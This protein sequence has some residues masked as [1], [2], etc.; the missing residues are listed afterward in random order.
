MSIT[1]TSIK[2]LTKYRD[3]L[4]KIKIW[5]CNTACG[6]SYLAKVDKR[7]YDLD[8]YRSKMMQQGL[9][10]FDDRTIP[11]MYEILKKGKIVLNSSHVHI[12]NYLDE[13][14][15]PFVYMYARPE[16]QEEYV[17]RMRNRG[18][19]EEF[20]QKF[21]PMISGHYSERIKDE[22]ATFKIEMHP[23]EYVSDY[24]LEIFGKN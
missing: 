8:A 14:K 11:K 6:K 13:N 5:I 18:S 22:R 3:K 20:I 7:F 2:D 23:N 16:C 15:I 1:I 10:D 12:L 17:L 4:K 19:S 24:L 9:K 21:A